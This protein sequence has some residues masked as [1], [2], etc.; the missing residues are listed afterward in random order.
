MTIG[1]LAGR[2]GLAPHVLRHWE[3]MG[4]LAPDRQPNGRR[5]YQQ[6][7]AGQVGLILLGKEAGFSLGQLRAL[8]AN[9]DDPTVW[10]QLLTEQR[11]VLRRRIS[12]SRTSLAIISHALDSDH[13]D[14]TECT[15]LVNS[16][17]T[18]DARSESSPISG[19]PD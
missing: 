13:R 8:L 16:M 18:T 1:E 12:D 5:R 17:N 19:E 14:L 9:R 15:E 6:K 4:L 7:H 3:A 11:N 10:R 2:F